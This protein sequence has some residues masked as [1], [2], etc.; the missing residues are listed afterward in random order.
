MKLQPEYETE[1][2]LTKSGYYAIRQPQ[3]D[4]S[5]DQIILLSKAQVEKVVADMQEALNLVAPW[6]GEGE[7]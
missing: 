2:Y 5:E 1:C 4:G 7:R 6:P 3:L